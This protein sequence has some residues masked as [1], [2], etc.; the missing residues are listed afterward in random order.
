MKPPSLRTRR[1]LLRELSP[2]DAEDVFAYA[3]DPE[4]T[5]NL[6]WGPHATIEESAQYLR[7]R[8]RL[9]EEGRAMI[10]GVIPLP[11]GRLIGTCGF[12]RIYHSERRAELAVAISRVHKGRGL[13]TEALREV[14]RFGFEGLGLATIFARTLVE[15]AASTRVL[16]KTGMSYEHEVK[17]A[18]RIG[19]LRRKKLYTISAREFRRL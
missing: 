19:T 13:A 8:I 7:E 16:E 10:W 12:R 15:N 6:T 3:S 17:E 14:L 2:D 9:C 11:E 1:L 4:V 18:W 5:R